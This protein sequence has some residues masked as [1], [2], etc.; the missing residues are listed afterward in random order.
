MWLDDFTCSEKLGWKRNY[1]STV[2]DDYNQY[3]IYW[4]HCV[5]LKALPKLKNWEIKIFLQPTKEIEKM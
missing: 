2:L 1:L 5:I 4:E 3:I